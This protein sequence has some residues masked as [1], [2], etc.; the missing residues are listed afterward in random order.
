[1]ESGGLGLRAPTRRLS[2][3]SLTTPDSLRLEFQTDRYNTTLP[4]LQIQ[5]ADEILKL[6]KPTILVLVSALELTRATPISSAS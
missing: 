6:G 4:G 5:L 3:P 2:A 1:M